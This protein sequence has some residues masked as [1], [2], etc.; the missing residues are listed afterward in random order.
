MTRPATIGYVDTQN[1]STFQTFMTHNFLCDYHI[2]IYFSTLTKYLVGCI[3]QVPDCIY[4]IVVLRY[5][6]YVV[7]RYDLLCDGV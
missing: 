2:T 4:S 1:L 5:P 7:L 3:I 6:L